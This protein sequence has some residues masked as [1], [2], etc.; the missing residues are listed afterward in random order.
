MNWTLTLAV[1]AAVT[2]AMLYGPAW[3]KEKAGSI[4]PG[5][6]VRSI[7]LLERN[8]YSC[9]DGLLWENGGLWL[10]DEGGQ[11]LRRWTPEKTTLAHSRRPE[12]QSPEDLV[13]DGRGNYYYTDDSTGSVWRYRGGELTKLAGKEQ[14]LVS[15]EGIALAADGRLLVGDGELHAIFE[16]TE[17]QARQ[18]IT[19]VHKPES[20]VFDK[21]GGLY[22]ADNEEHLLYYWKD[23]SLEVVL[24]DREISPETIAGFGDGLLMTDSLHGRLYVFHRGRRPEVLA[25]FGGALRKVHGVTPDGAGHVFVSVQTDLAQGN[26]HLFRLTLLP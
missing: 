17:G 3:P 8:G 26:G 25:S 16:V 19:G 23:G 1:P 7:E 14:G 22:I 10:A 18:V 6:G 24:R 11:G 5:R 15:T 13:T 21:D 2:V 20:L 4:V 12:I 9:P